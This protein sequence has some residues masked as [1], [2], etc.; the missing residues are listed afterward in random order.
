MTSFLDKQNLY[1]ETRSSS[2]SVF[3]QV[4]KFRAAEVGVEIGVIC[5]GQVE[6]FLRNTNLTKLYGVA[7]YLHTH[8]FN[9]LL[10]LNQNELDQLQQFVTK[11]MESFQDRYVHLQKHSREAIEDINEQVDFVFFNADLTYDEAW[12]N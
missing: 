6:S 11:R 12:D 10:N 3:P 1:E 8:A 4:L 5:G 2:Y 7:H 9:N